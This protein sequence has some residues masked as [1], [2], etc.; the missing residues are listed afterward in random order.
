M[1]SGRGGAE[2][3][4]RCL[5]GRRCPG[6]IVGLHNGDVVAVRVQALGGADE[7]GIAEGLLRDLVKAKAVLVAEPVGGAIDADAGHRLVEVHL[8]AARFLK[9]HPAGKV[10]SPST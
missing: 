2:A 5:L 7:G 4:W 3:C 8:P 1:I 10:S 6:A 9:Q